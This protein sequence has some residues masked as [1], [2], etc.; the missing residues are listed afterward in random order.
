MIQNQWVFQERQVSDAVGKAWGSD[1]WA[2]HRLR[3]HLLTKKEGSWWP[4]IWGAIFEILGKLEPSCVFWGVQPNLGPRPKKQNGWLLQ[5]CL[6]W[7][8]YCVLFGTRAVC[9]HSMLRVWNHHPNID[10]RVRDLGESVSLQQNGKI[11]RAQSNCKPISHQGN[12]AKGN[13]KVS[14]IELSNCKKGFL[15]KN[16]LHFVQPDLILTVGFFHGNWFF[17]LQKWALP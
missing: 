17:Q 7:K 3:G 4:Q 6:L 1:G 9:G 2:F 5:K 10:L 16:L 8:M 13:R 11:F 15:S 12:S 14:Y